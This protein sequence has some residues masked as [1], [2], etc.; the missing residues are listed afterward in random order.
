MALSSLFNG[1]LWK[2]E[3]RQF[4]SERTAQTNPNY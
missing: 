4:K 3:L 2:A 1:F